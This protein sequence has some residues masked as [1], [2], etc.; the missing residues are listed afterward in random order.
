[1]QQEVLLMPPRLEKS[2]LK[3]GIQVVGFRC[4][5]YLRIDLILSVFRS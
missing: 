2:N 4:G 1:M 5:A 3:L